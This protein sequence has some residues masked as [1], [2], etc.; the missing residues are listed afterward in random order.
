LKKAL[1]L[2]LISLSQLVFICG[3]GTLGIS[4]TAQKSESKAGVIPLPAYS[5]PKARIAVASFEVRSEKTDAEIGAALRGMLLSG[6][7]NSGRFSILELPSA[8]DITPASAVKNDGGPEQKDRAELIITVSVNEFEPQASGG[9][10]GVGGGGGV[11]SGVLGGL[12]GASVNKAHIALEIRIVNAANSEVVASTRVQG[13][14]SDVS[15]RSYSGAP[16]GWVLG[17]VLSRYV[18]TPMEQAIRSCMVEAVRY[19]VQA[20]PANYSKY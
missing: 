19:I 6:V 15:I 3:C 8:Q 7:T 2:L 16:E 14:A 20:V 13:Q 12:L 18:N 9:R 17:G 5:G 10:E 1:L 4:V 11:S